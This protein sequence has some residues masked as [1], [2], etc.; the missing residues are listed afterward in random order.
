MT[1]CQNLEKAGTT[2][3]RTGTKMWVRREWDLAGIAWCFATINNWAVLREGKGI[4]LYPP[5]TV[6][7]ALT[8]LSTPVLI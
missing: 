2:T 7:L 4:H 8:T 5:P 3:Q 6:P 1:R